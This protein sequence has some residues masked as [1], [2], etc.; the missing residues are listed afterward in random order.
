MC[1]DYDVYTLYGAQHVDLGS[2]ES[3]Q[4]RFWG[5]R[6]SAPGWMKTAKGPD[7]SSPAGVRQLILQSEEES[8][9][10]TLGGP[11]HRHWSRYSAVGA[12]PVR[13]CR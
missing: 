13:E 9:Q 12:H 10:S 2:R 8:T 11:M 4:L 7:A 6:G 5:F 3:L 1:I